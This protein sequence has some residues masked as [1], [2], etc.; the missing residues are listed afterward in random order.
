MKTQKSTVEDEVVYYAQTAQPKKSMSKRVGW[1]LAA[2]GGVL[3][4]GFWTAVIVALINSPP[5]NT[6]VIIPVENSVESVE[7]ESVSKNTVILVA[8]QPNEY[9][10]VLTLNKGT[11]F[12]ETQY[13]YYLPAGTY[14]VKNVNEKYPAQIN[15][16]SR[17]THI[18]EA[19]WEEPS[20]TIFAKLLQVGESV[21]V[22]IK[23]DEYIEIHEPDIL[24]MT[25]TD[26]DLPSPSSLPDISSINQTSNEQVNVYTFTLNTKTKVYHTSGCSAVKKITPDNIK[27]VTI[28]ATTRYQAELELIKDGYRVCEICGK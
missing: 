7:E 27:M 25:K 15:V 17:E 13:V 1:T 6:N 16:Y 20:E 14:T 24:E 22:G 26:G 12:E 3:V 11:E 10:E 28:P 21:E 19:G 18:N 9:A 8:G 23:E 4:V 2:I 5:E